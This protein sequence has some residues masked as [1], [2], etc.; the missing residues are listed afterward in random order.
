[1]LVLEAVVDQDLRFWHAFF[2]LP[3]TLN[4]LNILD[5]SPLMQDLYSGNSPA[6]S[7]SYTLG[8]K[9]RNM[10]YYLADG[11]YP[12][13]PIFVK[14]IKEPSD[15]KSKLFAR[16]QEACRKDVE[17]AFG[18]LQ[19]RLQRKVHPGICTSISAKRI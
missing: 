8:E 14:S 12:D 1:M 9:E 2:G 15:E 19:A 7:V 16:F 17:R 3:G 10:G 5:Q 6:T 13:Y 11:I 18:V 4:D